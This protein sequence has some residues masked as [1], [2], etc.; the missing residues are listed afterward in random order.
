M[1]QTDRQTDKRKNG[2]EK[3]SSLTFISMTHV[4]IMT[5]RHIVSETQT[6]RQTDRQRKYIIDIYI[7]DT[8]NLYKSL[9]ITL[10]GSNRLVLL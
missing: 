5:L 6:D 4:T 3:F 2:H 9:V 1:T 7:Y 8:L 10:N